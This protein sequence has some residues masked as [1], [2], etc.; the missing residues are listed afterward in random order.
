MLPAING[1]G[2]SWRP[3]AEE[4]DFEADHSPLGKGG[5]CFPKARDQRSMSRSGFG[6][7][8]I[9]VEEVNVPA[10]IASDEKLEGNQSSQTQTCR[11]DSTLDVKGIL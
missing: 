8:F 9:E 1:D 2:A 11:S 5:F 6:F 3:I 7:R 4:N 10:A